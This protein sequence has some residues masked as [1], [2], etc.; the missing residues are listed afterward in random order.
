MTFDSEVGEDGSP[1][2]IGNGRWHAFSI[3]K[4]DL[5]SGTITFANPWSSGKPITMSLDE[6]SQKIATISFVDTTEQA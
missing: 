2:V 1:G 4:I 6:A 5:A 3:E